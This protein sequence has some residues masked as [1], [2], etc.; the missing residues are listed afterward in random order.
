VSDAAGYTENFVGKDIFG[1]RLDKT[2]MTPKD[3]ERLFLDKNID[4]S[5]SE[6]SGAWTINTAKSYKLCTSI[7]NCTFNAHFFRN[8]Q[9]GDSSDY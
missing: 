8:F 9:T 5:A 6:K 7:G 1:P 4:S 3:M 2:L